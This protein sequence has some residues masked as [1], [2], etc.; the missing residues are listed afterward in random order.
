VVETRRLRKQFGAP[1]L[2]LV[3]GQE[4]LYDPRRA[5]GRAHRL[6]PNLVDSDLVPGPAM[7]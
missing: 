2:P 6:L 4:T 5:L 1:A 7:L 3:A